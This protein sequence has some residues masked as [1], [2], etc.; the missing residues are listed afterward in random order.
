MLTLKEYKE[1][2]GENYKKYTEQ[3]LESMLAFQTELAQLI[4]EQLTTEEDE[5]T[6]C[7]D[8]SSVK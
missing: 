6:S 1:L 4:V 2:F 8:V 5:K 7:I 3:E